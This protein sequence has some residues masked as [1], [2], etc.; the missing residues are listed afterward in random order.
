VLVGMGVERTDLK[1]QYMIFGMKIVRDM[2]TL[3]K[4]TR[5]IDGVWDFGGYLALM[6][7]MM[8][9]THVQL[10]LY[11]GFFC[12]DGLGTQLRTS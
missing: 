7:C 2:S 1:F 9:D 10:Y 6:C 8:Y 5:S 3:W 11:L 4:K 12:L